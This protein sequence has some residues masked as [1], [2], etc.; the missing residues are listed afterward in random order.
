MG[1]LQVYD[2]LPVA[3]QHVAVSAAGARM[4][5]RRYRGDFGERLRAAEQR[6]TWS[7][8]QLV[9]YRDR[10]VVA[11]ARHAAASVPHYR[12]ALAAAGAQLGDLR[13]PADVAAVFGVL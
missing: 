13:G 4:R 7:T 5:H 6:G 9:E 11:H 2:R 10:R 12:D 8:E 3:L 1:V